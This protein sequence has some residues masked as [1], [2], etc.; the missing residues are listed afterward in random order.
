MGYYAD[1]IDTDFTI[2]AANIAA[3]LAAVNSN[4]DFGFSS[5]TGGIYTSLDEFVRDFTSFEENT[6]DED[7]FHLG[8]HVDKFLSYTE[9]VLAALAPAVTEG[10][11]VRFIGEEQSL[12]GYRVVDGKLRTETGD[13]IWRL[14]DQSRPS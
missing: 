3:T 11:Y 5:I 14:D 13:I 7:G 2:P 8:H 4:K 6:E 10:S 9:E 1:S 12:F